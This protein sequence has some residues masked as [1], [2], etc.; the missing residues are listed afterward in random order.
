MAEAWAPGRPPVRSAAITLGDRDREFPPIVL[1]RLRTIE[2]RVVNRQGRPV[3]GALVFQ[4]GDGPMRTETLADQDGRFALP[5]VFEG[6]AIVLARKDGFRARFQPV[7]DGAASIRIALARADEA[8]IAAYKTLPPALPADEEK[9]L[10]RRLVQPEAGRVLARGD[11]RAK[12]VFLPN[13]AAFDPADAARAAR[14]GQ[15]RR[16]RR[17]RLD[18]DRRRRGPG[19]GEPRRGAGRRRDSQDPRASH[20]GVSRGAPGAARPRAGPRRQILDQAIVNARSPSNEW[21]KIYLLEQIAGRLLDLGEIERAKP[22]IREGEELARKTLRDKMLA[23][24]LASFAGLMLRVNPAAALP[25]VR[26][27]EAADRRRPGDRA[28][29]RPRWA[30]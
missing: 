21:Q 2:G 15:A 10:A 7:D 23:N 18:P 6:P 4:S 28:R 12:F 14:G 27:A 26:G 3:A 19:P 20:P 8:P 29:L 16:P 9:A 22:L 13:L 17:R 25:T 24:R 11:D 30:L 1:R 5:G